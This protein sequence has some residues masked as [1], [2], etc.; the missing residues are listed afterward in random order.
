MRP[1]TDVGEVLDGFD[2]VVVL[3][4]ENRSF[5]NLLG[6]LYP[7]GVPDNAPAGKTFQG[8]AG[9]NLAN[10]IPATAT[11]QSAPPHDVTS[12]PVSPVPD[13]PDYHQPYPDPREQYYR[14]NT[15]LFNVID[16]ND[17]APYNVP[18]PVP[19]TPGCRDS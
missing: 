8:V 6:Y 3:M 14:V 12:I 1:T 17:K 11:G 9:K 18:S 16:G 2:Y 19:A 5:D 10:P 7:D 15:Q 13:P 4:L